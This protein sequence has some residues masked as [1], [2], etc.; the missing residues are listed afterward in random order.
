M[1]VAEQ[2]V[3]ELA[4]DADGDFDRAI[5]GDGA[6]LKTG[7][8][9]VT[10]SAAS[11]YSGGTTV[12]D[13][14]LVLSDSQAA[15]SAT[16]MINDGKTLQLG[17]SGTFTGGPTFS[18]VLSGSGTVTID[19]SVTRDRHDTTFTGDFNVNDTRT[20]TLDYADDVDFGNVV[21]GSGDVTK[22]GAGTLTISGANTNTGTFT[23]AAD[24]V[25]LVSNWAGDYVQSASSGEFTAASGA[26]VSG[27]ATFSGNVNLDEKL[28][29]GSLAFDGATI[30]FD[31][32][33]DLF[34]VD[35][36]GDVT[37]SGTNTL[38]PVF[39]SGVQIGLYDIAE[40][41]GGAGTVADPTGFWTYTL[42]MTHLDGYSL[43]ARGSGIVRSEDDKKL[44][45]RV[46]LN[47]INL[48]WSGAESALW[49]NNPN[50]PDSGNWTNNRTGNY[51]ETKFRDRDRVTFDATG[52][53][54]T[55]V[56]D[57]SLT[58]GSL[59]VDG[60]TYVFTGSGGV[61]V[62]SISSG[63]PSGVVTTGVL[64]LSN[65]ADL[66]LANS[67]TNHSVGG[68]QIDSGSTLRIGDGGATGNLGGAIENDG[69]V[70]LNRS[71]VYLLDNAISGTGTVRMDGT[72]TATVGGSGAVTQ[73]NDFVQN[74]GIVDLAGV[75]A[76]DYTQNAGALTGSGTLS[77]DLLAAKKINPTGTLTIDGDADFSGTTIGIKMTDNNNSDKIAVTGAATLGTGADITTIDIL[78]FRP[79]EY[80]ILTAGA[81]G[82]PIDNDSFTTL[83]GGGS[84]AA[85][86]SVDYTKS[87]TT[88]V[89]VTLATLGNI[90]LTW[91]GS[92]GGSWRSDSWT[93]GSV[94]DSFVDGDVVIFDDSVT[95]PQRIDLGTGTNT[96]ASITVAGGEYVFTGFG[97]IVGTNDPTQT[98]LPDPD[99]KLTL[100]SG[101]SATFANRDANSFAG[102]TEIAQGAILTLG[103]NDETGSLAGDIVNEGSFVL[104]RSDAFT[105]DNDISGAG[106]TFMNGTG[107]VTI[108]GTKTNDFV[109]NDGT[110]NL[111]TAW[112]GDYDLAGGT[113]TGGGAI[114]GA[115]SI[116]SV[117]APTGTLTLEN[118]TFYGN[119]T[120]AIGTLG[121]DNVIVTNTAAFD[122]AAG[123]INV[124]LATWSLDPAGS[125]ILAGAGNITVADLFNDVTL[126][127]AA[128]GGRQTAELSIVS[129]DLLMKTTASNELRTWTGGNGNLWDKNATSN[130]LE[131]DQLFID[132]DKAAF[133]ASGALV[134]TIQVG[135]NLIASEMTID[136]DTDYSFS[137]ASI[138]TDA[139]IW[140][141][142]GTASG[143]L[144]K[145]GSGT[146]TFNNANDF[147]SG[148]D[149]NA[150]RINI[151]NDLALG[152]Q[153]VRMQA[154]STLGF[155]GNHTIS[156][157]ISLRGDATI[158]S[159]ANAA[160][161]A[162][163]ISGDYTL[164]K[165]GSGSLTL[166][167]V[168]THGATRVAEGLLVAA[169]EN[170][171][172]SGGATIDA[173]AT[174]RLDFNGTVANGV[175]GSGTLENQG[176]LV[177]SGDHANFTGTTFVR[178]GTT[179]LSSGFIS[180]AA[181]DV[182]SAL[183][184][185]GRLGGDL[186]VRTGATLSPGESIGRI[187]TAGNVLFEDGA[188]YEVEIDIAADTA[189][190]LVATGDV[191]VGDTSELH[192]EVLDV[193]NLADATEY[194][195]IE[196]TGGTI[197]R[198]FA[199]DH[200]FEKALYGFT[201]NLRDDNR[202]YL[203]LRRKQSNFA[204]L[205]AGLGYRNAYNA[206][207]GVDAID[208][209]GLS[210]NLGSLFDALGNLDVD[211]QVYLAAFRQLHGE[212]FASSR[213]AVV[214]AQRRFLNELPSARDRALKSA[215]TP[216]GGRRTQ[217]LNRWASFTGARLDRDN[218]GNF[219][220][221]DLR[222]Y[223][224]AFGMD[225]DVTKKL[226]VGAAFG[227]DDG[228]LKFDDLRSR[229]E[230][231]MF[232]GMLYGGWRSGRTYADGYAGYVNNRHKTRRDVNIGNFAGT[233]RSKFND[234]MF[235]TGLEVGRKLR[236][237][238]L[239]VMPSIGLHYIYLDSPSV[240]ETGADAANLRIA[241][242]KYDSLRLPVGARVSRDFQGRRILW[243]S[244][245]RAFYVT[246]MGD[247]S[248]S[249]RTAFHSVRDVGFSASSGSW[250]RSSGLFGV[251][252][253]GRLSDRLSLQI[254]YDYQLY[255][256]TDMGELSVSA[257]VNW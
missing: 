251:G 84:L 87:D 26:T 30:A 69:T 34:K 2:A 59:I 53:E 15:G 41:D 52:A 64:G 124:D 247:D 88:A 180:G 132:G 24:D 212:L 79:G 244:E 137:G 238:G 91:N 201:Q 192:V 16:I 233:A 19:A 18:N 44:Q 114:D 98:D 20:L 3:L 197:N 93:D 164:T 226:Y 7:D 74:D 166:S 17:G 38:N 183:A 104:N 256:H 55:V 110:V 239:N 51:L 227:Y 151:G 63:D 95:T 77:G 112:T 67:G 207:A 163:N 228:T 218:L 101:A 242:G 28:E 206:A 153:V 189:D 185:S 107:D 138:T 14:V 208:A 143:K 4:Y 168:N 37:F 149:L 200:Y 115:A 130:W 49:T 145:S 65:N 54:K 22:T 139:S 141:G 221:Y 126:G 222:T 174:L 240:T 120:L 66:T 43:D 116:R 156:N 11:T 160:T 9:T 181:Y 219:S 215:C 85:R 12:A 83:V 150:G 121:T 119:S 217:K 128:L 246:E 210:A 40:I 237:G 204:D 172:A 144:V 99:G 158:D 135:E 161:V 10:L 211:A 169:N 232:R 25:R 36:T 146:A 223:G 203:T 125:V 29:V 225:K 82:A 73:T 205:L 46:A 202:L 178:T 176:D 136:A 27:T 113:L 134:P 193:A 133:G 13:G 170:A 254:D 257:N 50:T 45:L 229:D 75:W 8:H 162:N 122:V 35:A 195:V 72:G 165:T 241:G 255:E 5:S 90:E 48:V 253:K 71:D 81:F 23:Q 6:V 60:A 61:T 245:L 175:S 155:T 111:A 236:F 106:T 32:G 78:E 252:V 117:V 157:A 243:T 249:V 167:A 234:D 235:S 196:S 97:G 58:A 102:G 224:V 213:E 199:D 131:N 89:V 118:A 123:K 105:L 103:R 209:A 31:I 62:D 194:L 159:G 186:T 127:G 184:G 188:K 152:T 42:G 96:V 86:Q 154:D 76:G 187:E 182:S 21:S 171:L 70:V 57:G 231:D 214:Q 190:R 198:T 179:T 147:K 173:G 248:A 1:T 100:A 250:G 94:S 68:T 177:L 216:C 230:T 140:S 191:T 129:G 109:Q 33:T 47:N 220:G 108:S 56:L 148:T 39:T 80:T 92:D 142:N